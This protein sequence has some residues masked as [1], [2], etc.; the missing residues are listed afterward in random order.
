[1]KAVRQG[2][3][4]LAGVRL[5]GTLKAPQASLFSE[6]PMS[7]PDAFSYLL[8]GRKAREVDD[9]TQQSMAATAAALGLSEQVG[10]SGAL[11]ST[12]GIDSVGMETTERRTAPG[13]TAE[14]SAVA[15]GKR[16]SPALYVRYL[17]GLFETRDVVQLRYDVTP[18]V[19]V[20]SETGARTG[21]DVFFT[22]ER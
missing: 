22:I 12:L 11:R 9:P 19:Q 4:A 1:V 14:E 20:Q 16:L 13:V 15:I 21:A 18:R 3:D 7:Q 2:P 5:T 17:V 8:F 6:P 10:L